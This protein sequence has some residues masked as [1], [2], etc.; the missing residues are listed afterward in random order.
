MRHSFLSF[1]AF[2]VSIPLLPAQATIE[3]SDTD[4][5]G[6]V[7]GDSDLS[8][9]EAIQLA[10][11]DISL[12]QLSSSEQSYVTGIPGAAV[13]DK[14]WFSFFAFPGTLTITATLTTLH[15]GLD[16][17][18]GSNGGLY[19]FGD[20][21]IDGGGT[22]PGFSITG[23]ETTVE[24][25]E[26]T[27]IAGPVIKVSSP[28][29][30][31]CKN[32]Q[33]RDSLLRN[34]GVGV[35]VDAPAGGGGTIGTSAQPILVS[36]TT[37]KD[38]T[39]QGASSIGI[40]VDGGEGDNSSVYVKLLDSLVSR[41][42][43][44]ALMVIGGSTGGGS[45]DNNDITVELV[46]SSLDVSFQGA[47]AI[48]NGGDGNGNEVDLILRHATIRG[49][50]KNGLLLETGAGDSNS[51]LVT[52][53]LS[54]IASNN[55]NGIRIQGGGDSSSTFLHADLLG[56]TFQ[57]N[58]QDAIQVNSSA[59]GTGTGQN[60]CVTADSNTFLSNKRCVLVSADNPNAHLVD[61]DLSDN[62]FETSTS[63]AIRVKAAGAATTYKLLVERN[64]FRGN[65]GGGVVVASGASGTFNLDLGRGP[66]S[67]FGGNTFDG[68][69]ACG[70]DNQSTKYVY[71]ID[72]DWGDASG[73]SDC[74][75]GDS[76]GITDPSGSGDGC[77]EYCYFSPFVTIDQNPRLTVTGS[78]DPPSDLTILVSE[79]VTGAPYFLFGS[80]IL[81]NPP[82][83]T[84][85]GNNWY[86]GAPFFFLIPG[87]VGTPIGPF[88]PPTGLPEGLEVYLAAAVAQGHGQLTNFASLR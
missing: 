68:S 2:L 45:G 31:M 85:L 61:L 72:N 30:G 77:G 87:L 47:G 8:L 54:M 7:L 88:P 42:T 19:N 36:R 56:C 5:H 81:L 29:G 86:L 33:I 4:S 22:Q 82:K 52:A 48:L 58:G 9:D 50:K 23:S 57:S 64:A 13:A 44:A 3:V 40:D 78:I 76:D 10:N 53:T 66:L 24:L 79:G 51:V 28:A 27:R 49:F 75:A 25:I 35:E 65:V 21:L 16:T 38:I 12:C 37:V 46:D 20:I 83:D 41:P 70:I 60:L 80:L 67:S 74:N 6:G 11:G 84:F 43:G 1:A 63:E 32:V 14:I 34:S 55:E 15:A 59:G 69:G 17:I 39:T 62:F 18:D 26:I 71:A 73:P